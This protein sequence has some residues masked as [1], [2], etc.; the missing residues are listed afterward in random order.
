MLPT[1]HRQ[2]AEASP[3]ALFPRK[4]ALIRTTAKGNKENCAEVSKA[5]LGKSQEAAASLHA[6]K[7]AAR[8]GA[9]EFKVIACSCREDL[10][11]AV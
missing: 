1:P 2:E 11:C 5:D 8:L 7:D 9:Q 3:G 10:F 6:R 4:N